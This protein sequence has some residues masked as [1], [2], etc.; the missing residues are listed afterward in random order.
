MIF[1]IGLLTAA[2]V[3]HKSENCYN[4]EIQQFPQS[5]IATTFH[6]EPL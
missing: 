3:P 2:T 4:Q 1:A 5:L 6:F